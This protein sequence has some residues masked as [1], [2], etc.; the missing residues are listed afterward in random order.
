MLP[1]NAYLA[2]GVL[3]VSEQ[4]LRPERF[5]LSEFYLASFLFPVAQAAGLREAST[6]Q[7][8]LQ[9]D[10]DSLAH[11]GVARQRFLRLAAGAG[12]IP[13]RDAPGGGREIEP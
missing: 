8:E 11:A 1:S 6:R 13:A 9:P 4:F 7:V 12:S 5:S 3:R 2:V 10:H